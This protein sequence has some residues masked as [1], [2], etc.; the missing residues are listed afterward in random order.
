DVVD[1]PAANAYKKYCLLTDEQ[2]AFS[3][4]FVLPLT[5]KVNRT[6]IQNHQ[7][8]VANYHKFQDIAK[9][10]GTSKDLIDLIIIDEPHHQAANTYQELI[11]FSDQAKIIG[12]TATPFP[13]DGKP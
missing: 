11:K 13:S 5:Q 1:H 12:L 10:F 3:D 7:I 2:I 9:W 6:D 8:I 4:I